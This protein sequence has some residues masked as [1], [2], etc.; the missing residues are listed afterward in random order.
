MNYKATI[1]DRPEIRLVVSRA[2]EFPGDI[3]GAW[4]RLESKLSSLRGRRFYGLAFLDGTRWTYYAGLEPLNEEEISNLGF[5]TMVVKGGRYARVKLLNWSNQTEKI[6]EI[7]AELMREYPM[8]PDGPAVEYYR[9]QS[10]LHLLLPLKNDKI[11]VE[12]H[13]N[14]INSPA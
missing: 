14:S 8:A 1:V 10:E 11:S 6:G 13:G 12:A 2:E 4:D 7:F 3:K 9:S 5:Q